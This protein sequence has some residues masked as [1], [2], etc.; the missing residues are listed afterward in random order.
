MSHAL[1]LLQNTDTPVLHVAMSVGYASASRFAARFRACFG[2]LP[3]DIR[4]Q[5]RSRRTAFVLLHNFCWISRHHE[6]VLADHDA[7]VPSGRSWSVFRHTH[8]SSAGW[9][10]FCLSAG[11]GQWRSGPVPDAD[12]KAVQ[13]AIAWKPQT[14]SVTFR[15]TM[16]ATLQRLLGGA[17]SSMSSWPSPDGTRR[18]SV[19]QTLAGGDSTLERTLYAA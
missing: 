19:V 15:S 8:L 5:H 3:T 6:R 12:L 13:A 2:D 4:G 7:P 9:R 14:A 16:P 10:A 11:D 1:A 18:D 17:L